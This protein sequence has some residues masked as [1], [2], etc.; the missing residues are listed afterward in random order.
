VGDVVTLSDKSNKLT[1]M[2][3]KKIPV[4]LLTE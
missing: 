3:S 1:Q 2:V 4:Q